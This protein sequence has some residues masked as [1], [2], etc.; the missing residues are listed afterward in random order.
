MMRPIPAPGYRPTKGQRNP[1]DDGRK[2]WVQLATEHA[3]MGWCDLHAPWPVKGTKWKW[4]GDTPAPW[5]V[6]AVKIEA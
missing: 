4:N 3:G 2:Y 5:D 6:V 1:A